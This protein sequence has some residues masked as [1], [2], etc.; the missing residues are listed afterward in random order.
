MQK[1]IKKKHRTKTPK[2]NKTLSQC[3]FTRM[4]SD[5]LYQLISNKIKTNT[6]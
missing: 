3:G 2:N 1:T 6:L 4:V 5:Y